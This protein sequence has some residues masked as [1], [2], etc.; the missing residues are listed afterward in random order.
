VAP[1]V[2]AEYG[3]VLLVALVVQESEAD[4]AAQRHLT[5]MVAS[6]FNAQVMSYSQSL[7]V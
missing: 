1:L 5:A 7:R 6:L 3:L 2:A 4:L